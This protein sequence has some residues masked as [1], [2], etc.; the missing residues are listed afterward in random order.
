[1]RVPAIILAAG[2]SR[3][4]G[5]PKQLVRIAGE[6]LLA[7]TLR[8]V[9]EAECEP[10]LVVLGAHREEIAA[11]VDLSEVEVIL[12]PDWEQGIATS[13]QAG[14]RALQGVDPD[15]NAA[16]ILVCDQPR[17]TAEH[18]R[19][20]VDAHVRAG[21]QAIVASGYAGTSGIPAIFPA[22]QFT[23][24]L[25]LRGDAGARQLLRTPGNFLVTVEFQEGEIDIDTPSDLAEQQAK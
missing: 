20:L 22:S 3:R 1:M 9:R 24:L 16:F 19:K 23:S 17:L 21:E 2:A 12:N 6:G 11:V 7:R 18:L 10:V 25:A 14:I 5:Q 4:L 15:S 8:I 13:I